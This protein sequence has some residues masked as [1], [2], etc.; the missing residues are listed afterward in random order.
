MSSL[1]N[2]EPVQ[3]GRGGKTGKGWNPQPQGPEPLTL[4]PCSF[5]WTKGA[6]KALNALTTM[7][8]RPGTCSGDEMEGT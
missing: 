1:N 7:A 4:G 8:V 3:Q 2:E 5:S 6:R